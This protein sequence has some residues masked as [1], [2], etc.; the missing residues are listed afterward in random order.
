M[1]SLG[2][3]TTKTAA[4][5]VGT[6]TSVGA[7]TSVGVGTSRGDV[8]GTAT[9]SSSTSTA[10]KSSIA[11]AVRAFETGSLAVLAISGVFALAGG[12][13]AVVA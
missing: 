7:G 9:G 5:S 8:A 4:A 12:S 3:T 6:G 10:T 2:T 13:W 11:G 1:S